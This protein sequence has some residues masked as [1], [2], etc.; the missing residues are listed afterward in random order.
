MLNVKNLL[1]FQLKKK[2]GSPSIYKEVILYM[3]FHALLFRL[4][5]YKKY[6]H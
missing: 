4:G 6:V 2:I 1:Q 5:L 3:V